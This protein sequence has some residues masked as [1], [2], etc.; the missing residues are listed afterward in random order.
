MTGTM[1]LA[2]VVGSS[3]L[4]TSEHLHRRG[5]VVFWSVFTRWVGI[6]L[7]VGI[8]AGLALPGTAPE[9]DRDHPAALA[10]SNPDPTYQT[11]TVKPMTPA[12]VKPNE[13]GR[14]PATTT[15][16]TTSDAQVLAQARR[17]CARQLESYS[18]VERQ[19]Q[20]AHTAF[21]RLDSKG[22]ATADEYAK[23]TDA[24]ERVNTRWLDA[25]SAVGACYENHG[26]EMGDAPVNIQP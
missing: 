13:L 15:D 20:R 18:K 1:N 21:D 11:P 12:E 17:A 8:I 7:A 10:L 3:T 14:S 9:S 25:V 4:G 26:A 5:V 16:R 6:A 24:F 19:K 22:N 23:A 2:R